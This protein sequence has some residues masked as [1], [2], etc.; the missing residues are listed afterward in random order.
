MTSSPPAIH[1]TWR[2]E[3]LVCAP[4]VLDV[5][6]FGAGPGAPGAF[7]DVPE[8]KELLRKYLECQ[9]LSRTYME[10]QELSRT[11]VECQELL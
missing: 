3:A 6:R 2:F 7:E 11:Y 5:V 8:C 10:C 9:E 4:A 1:K